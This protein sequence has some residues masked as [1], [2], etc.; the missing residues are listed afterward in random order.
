[1]QR[2]ASEKFARLR[3]WNLESEIRL[4]RRFDCI[5][6]ETGIP[7]PVVKLPSPPDRGITHSNIDASLV[8]KNVEAP[9]SSHKGLPLQKEGAKLRIVGFL[10][11][12]GLSPRTQRRLKV[13]VS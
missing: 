13:A 3:F 8:G 9:E 4:R 6:T 2:I 11:G 7:K 10:F 5:I 1:M 12:P